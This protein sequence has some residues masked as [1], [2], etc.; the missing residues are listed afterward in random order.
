MIKYYESA[1]AEVEG[2]CRPTAN[3]TVASRTSIH[4]NEDCTLAG[5][6]AE[7]TQAQHDEIVASG[8]I[9]KTQAEIAA[10]WPFPAVFPLPPNFGG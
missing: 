9:E 5:I 4:Y 6:M 3:V 7:V 1:C 2:N 10:I 8:G